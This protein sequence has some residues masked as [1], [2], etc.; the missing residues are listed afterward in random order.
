MV[1]KEILELLKQENILNESQIAGAEKKAQAEGLNIE[2]ILVREKLVD[3]E[4]LIE[5]KAKTKGMPYVN[6]M[7]RDVAKDA[8]NII[9][10][11]VAKNY[12]V[13]CFN[14]EKNRIDVGILDAGNFKAVEAINFLANEEGYQ[15]K[16]H[17]ISEDSFNKSLKQYQTLSE[18]IEVALK[19]REE[20]TQ[21]EKTKQDKQRKTEEVTKAAPVSKIVSVIL[22]HAVEGGASDIH[23][24]PFK[25][26]SRVRYRIDGI[27]NTSLVLPISVHGSIVARIKVLA[28][29]KL[30]ETRVPQ[31]GRIRVNF[32]KKRIDFRVSIL[33][34]IETEKV[35]MRILDVSRGA[36]TLED[37]GY[38]GH[39]LKIITDNIKQTDGL[40]LVTGPTGSGKST[41]LFSALTLIN[42][43]G[44]NISTLED[45]VEYFLDGANQSQI[46]DEVGFTFATGLRALLRQDPDII[47]VGEI[48]DSETAE[49]AIHAA[50]TGHMVLSTLH[51]NDAIGTIP[52]LIDMKVEPFLLASTLNGILAQRLVRRICSYCK[53]EHE[54]ND[55][56]KNTIKV[57]VEKI[58]ELVDD[59]TKKLFD[60]TILSK[61]NKSGMLY[62]GKGCARCGGS[63]YKGRVSIAEVLDVND[64]IRSIIANRK[65]LTHNS[66]FLKKQ[67]FITVQQDGIIRVLQGITSMEEVLRV[68]SG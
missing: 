15:V 39:N 25:K 63:G 60:E 58:Y 59:K 16:Y 67:K 8:L 53:I 40:F 64:D 35:V 62:K 7:E 32:G 48:R 51:T 27:L 50:L 9:S 42:K 45:P 28:N 11:E 13:I 43:E 44:V 33:P 6:L 22:K 65:E 23:I 29:L 34:L 10:P 31:D 54:M 3:S 1:N 5:I 21:S 24:E 49:L 12:R 18:E 30:D 61:G 19:A 47:M 66:E 36:P 41:T 2:D 52:R 4:K 57:E 68:M 55:E 14:K 20:E 17:L 26:E 37:L 56:V 46:R 38:E